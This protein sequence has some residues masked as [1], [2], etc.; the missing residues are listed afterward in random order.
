MLKLLESFDR[1]VWY[2]PG[3]R[4]AVFYLADRE[5][6]GVLINT[7]PYA[8]DLAHALG[9]IAPLN[10]AFFPSRFGAVDVAAWRKHGVKTMA[11]GAEA[12]H[13]GAIDSVID[14]E[15]RFSRTI[16]FLPMSG[17]TESSAAL[18]CKNKPGIVFFG[19]ILECNANGVPTLIAHEDDYS[20][21]NRLFGA[22][23]LQDLHYE[24]AFTDDFEPGHSQFGPG[25]DQLIKRELDSIFA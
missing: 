5:G 18:R 22:L 23:G 8:M 13:I 9:A 25:I 17:R 7:P 3:T 14:R 1:S 2:L 24:Y 4:P 10:Y 11:Y 20:W 15:Q 16:D 12:A 21:E 19:P 6:G